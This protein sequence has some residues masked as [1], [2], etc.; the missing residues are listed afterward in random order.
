[1][2]E[3]KK[4]LNRLTELTRKYPATAILG[5]RQVGKTTLARALKC[6]HWFDLEN[7]RDAQRLSDPLLTLD[8]LRGLIGIDEI[9]H[10][11]ALFPL[12]RHLVDQH[13]EQHYLLLGSAS[14]ELVRHSGESL[15]GRIA[16]H[17]LRGLSL[18]EVGINN[19]HQRWVRGGFP[20]AFLA[21]CE[22][23]SLDWRQNYIQAF[24]ERD[25]PNLGIHIPAATMRRFWMMLSHYHGQLLNY[26]ELGRS[27][28]ISDMTV[29]K[30]LDILQGTFMVRLLQPWHANVGKRQVKSPKLYLTDSGIFHSLQGIDNWNQLEAHPK[31]GSAWEGFALEIASKAIGQADESLFFYRTH[32]GTELD[33]LWQANGRWWGCEFKYASAP[34]VTPSIRNAI[35]DLGLA[36]VWIVHPGTETYPLAANVSALPIQALTDTWPY[37]EN[38]V[39]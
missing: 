17:Q 22:S 38:E 8:P 13:P 3:R 33:L 35:E 21:D 14:P 24:L 34:T 18:A 15:A 1:M 37:P 28:G 6:D 32:A 29:R 5:P 19:W 11:P 39:G 16:F 25:I 7:P 23:D 12:L 26:S 2:I 9:Q 4:E 30:Y 31:L 27:F 36:H 10:Q 20:K